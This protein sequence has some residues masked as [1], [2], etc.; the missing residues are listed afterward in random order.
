MLKK[1]K[2]S[3]FQ[4][5][6]RNDLLSLDNFDISD[7]KFGDGSMTVI[8]YKNSPLKFTIQI[9]SDSYHEFHYGYVTFSPTFERINSGGIVLN[10][11]ELQTKFEDWLNYDVKEYIFESSEIDLW[12]EFKNIT[13]SLNLDEINFDDKNS[14][15]LDEQNQISMALDELKL[16]IKDNFKT[17]QEQQSNVINRL[18]YLIE[19][20]KR[21]N[22][23][24]WKSVAIS[25]LISISI[26]LSLNNEQGELLFSLLKKVLST[27]PKLLSN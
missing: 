24:D 11:E 14:F 16:L 19:A 10:F 13:S 15:T 8:S 23:I 2:N 22:K 27:L 3:L 26:A 17:N 4:I 6:K 20:S 9:D 25:T 12:N 5:I 1:H 18:D 7:K 21:L